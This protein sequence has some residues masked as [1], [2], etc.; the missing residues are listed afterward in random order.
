MGSVDIRINSA[1]A[2]FRILVVDDMATNRLVAR[3]VLA[4]YGCEVEEAE[5]GE[6][7]LALLAERSYDTVLMDIMMPG[8]DGFEACHKVRTELELTLLP[9]IMLT[10]LSGPDDVAR[11]M[12]VGANDFIHKPFNATE[13]LARVKAAV[14]HKRLT[15]RLDDTESVLFALARMVEAKD[16]T[17][18]DHC[19]R[20]AHRSV[21]FG[22]HLGC[23]YEE[24]EALR[25][26]GVLH[27]IG[28][29]GIP[30]AILLKPGPLSD[31]EWG[32]MRQHPVIGAR[33]C[34][35]LKTMQLT[36]DIISSH[37]ERWDGSGYP[38][39]LKG[40]AIPRLARIF[41]LVD[42]FDALTSVRPYKKAFSVQKAIEIMQQECEQGFWDP[43]LLGQFITL[44]SS[45][46]G[47]L[48]LPHAYVGDKSSPIFES[49]AEL[50][51][52]A[53]HWVK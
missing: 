27:D 49:I 26:G 53:N 35:A 8:M 10:S 34:S 50:G 7:A 37:H 45:H 4:R 18:G 31:E 12:E 15:D 51:I 11:S 13:L 33:L 42:V 17:T 41:Q 3:S 24:L 32:V 9:I 20:L 36:I 23:K 52:D 6:K 22:K 29:L 28:K 5:S 47:E 25:R 40:E 19:D 39:G 21:V 30:D 38:K 44:L 16:L 46:V 1:I 14:S 48:E 43:E 2:P